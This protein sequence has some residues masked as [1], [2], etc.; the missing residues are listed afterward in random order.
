M[1]GLNGAAL[2]VGG[3]ETLLSRQLGGIADG[4]LES[5]RG[6]DTAVFVSVESGTVQT[7]A[8]PLANEKES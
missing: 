1:A 2:A 4:T 5:R 7:S 8:N 3:P 6:D